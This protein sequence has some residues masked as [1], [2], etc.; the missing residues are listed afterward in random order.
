MV[1]SGGHPECGGDELGVHGAGEVGQ[2]GAPDHARPRW[3][4]TYTLTE[5]GHHA[6]PRRNSS[7]H[8]PPNG[9]KP[10][11]IHPETTPGF[12]RKAV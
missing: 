3:A 12:V 2:A 10:A 8:R 6:E 5:T 9:P 4:P 1:A 11:E 7:A